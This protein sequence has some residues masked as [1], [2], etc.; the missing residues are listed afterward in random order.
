MFIKTLLFSITLIYWTQLIEILI[1]LLFF[2]F[3]I[4]CTLLFI[5]LTFAR[6]QLQHLLENNKLL[7]SLHYS[8]FTPT[9]WLSIRCIFIT[10][11][12][13]NVLKLIIISVANKIVQ[14]IIGLNNVHC[15]LWTD[16]EPSLENSPFID[17]N[18]KSTFHISSCFAQAIV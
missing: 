8:L 5:F 9:Y 13:Y 1:N 2:F 3:F 10:S 14:N 12:W 11:H 18:F 7:Y 15:K 17:Q 6:Q 16:I 4:L